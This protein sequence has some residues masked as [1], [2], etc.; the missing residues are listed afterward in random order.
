MRKMVIIIIALLSLTGCVKEEI[1]S[2][3]IKKY[4]KTT[5]GMDTIINIAVYDEDETLAQ[6][7]LDNVLELSVEWEKNIS[8]TEKDSF[9]NILNNE[10]RLL[11]SDDLKSKGAL[12]LILLSKK[13][14]ELTDGYFDITI[15]PLIKLWGFGEESQKV[16]KKLEIINE[17]KL[18]NY[19]NIEIKDNEIILLEGS[20]INLGG[21][22]KGYIADRIKKMMLEKGV[23]SGLINLGGNVLAVGSKEEGKPFIVGIREPIK[24]EGKIIGTV[25]VV[26]KSVVT[27]GVYE[28]NFEE[29]GAMYHHII[30]PKTGYPSRN[31]ILSV[32]II[33]SKSA[34]GDALSTSV[35]L[36]GEED[37]MKLIESL[38]NIDGIIINKDNEIITSKGLVSKYNFKIDQKLAH[39]KSYK[40]LEKK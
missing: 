34:D 36:L 18:V 10:R 24:E 9:V 3:K 30:D 1:K 11:I 4:D 17:K 13:Y 23:T 22:A 15:E 38:E 7:T 19:K 33:S 20:K 37:G 35:F 26:D 28:R 39:E 14:S 2:T 12:E 31:P 27:S 6:D 5:F 21:I 29:D 40:L 8:R 16:P 25:E 32:T